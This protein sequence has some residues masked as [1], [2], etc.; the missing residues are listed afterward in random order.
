MSTHSPVRTGVLTGIAFG[1][2]FGAYNIIFVD[3]VGGIVAGLVGGVLFGLGLG[4]FVAWQ[5]RRTAAN[6][7]SLA[8]ESVLHE[9]TA[10]HVA[11]VE[12]RGGWLYL[13]DKGLHFRAHKINVQR[14]PLF[15]ALADIVDVAPARA[16]G[17]IPNA[18][19]VTT[20][21]GSREKFIVNDRNGWIA[22]IRDATRKLKAA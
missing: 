1:A 19:T 8:G 17:L 18:L 20:M 22:A 11:N 21:Q 3:V 16:L 2:L 4:A 7:P 9:G 6:R 15:L 10:N 12:S 13:T 14:G 5:A